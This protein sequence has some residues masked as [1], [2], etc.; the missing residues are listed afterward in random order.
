MD[1]WQIAGRNATSRSANAE[2]IHHI[3]MGI[4]A[5]HSLST[6]SP[7]NLQKELDLQVALGAPLVAARGYACSELEDAY[8]RALEIGEQ[9]DGGINNFRVLWGLSS[10]YL[11]RGQLKKSLDLQ[12]AC[13]ALAE[14]DKN[15][16][17]LV[18]ASSWLGTILF[19]RNEFE[20]SAMW[21]RR[22]LEY[23]Q[24][25]SSAGHGSQYGLD[26]AVLAQVHLVW[27]HW[28]MGQT[29]KAHEL[30]EENLTFAKTLGHPL[31]YAH[32]LN[33]S[34]VLHSFQGNFSV[35]LSRADSLLY[36]SQK[37]EFPHY[38]AYAKIMRGLALARL[39][40]VDEGIGEMV[41]GLKARRD[42]GAELVRPMF[43][44]MLADVLA[45]NGQYARSIEALD[46]ADSIVEINGEHWYQAE[47][48]RVRGIALNRLS[49]GSDVALECVLGALESSE[50]I[51]ARSL[52]MRALMSLI[53]IQNGQTIDG[54][55]STKRLQRLAALVAG[56]PQ[57]V[58]SLDRQRSR[59]LLK[60]YGY[61]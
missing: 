2:A 19:Y 51:G 53:E 23:Y 6:V 40:N 5:L 13:A 38:I 28:L 36:L 17:E 35:A 15:P 32:A 34:V 59:D 33:F 10:F 24:T 55:E 22:A 57:S 58:P 43:L 30:D 44:T 29:V 56:L 49:P 47:S 4:T 61:D 60:S 18:Q 14:R 12:R 8:S 26:P 45:D 52:E 37:R 54:K 48:K 21:L 3:S 1:Y 27:L 42:T 16:G 39:D 50:K 41:A 20:D 31:S 46:E 25:G 9:L 11:I 7:E